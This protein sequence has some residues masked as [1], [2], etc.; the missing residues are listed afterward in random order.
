MSSN[1]LTMNHA[2]V[3]VYKWYSMQSILHSIVVCTG[4]NHGRDI[5]FRPSINS[6]D[7]FGSFAH[8]R[9]ALALPWLS[10]CASENHQRGMFIPE[11]LLHGTIVER[12]HQAHHINT[13]SSWSSV[14]STK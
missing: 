5:P 9:C 7:S 4:V 10:L 8:Q 6:H 3:E 13:S 1:G 14:T 11:A 12:H 2:V